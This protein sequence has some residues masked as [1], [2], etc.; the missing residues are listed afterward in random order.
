MQTLSLVA[1][2]GGTGKTTLAL[3]LAVAAEAAGKT[4]LIIDL[5]PQASACKWGDRR[6]SDGP[7]VIDAQP[8]RLPNALEKAAHAGVDLAIVDT[9]AR[10]EQAAAEAARASDL[11]IIPCKPSIYDLETLHATIDL[12]QSR[13]KRP[14]IV[15]L[16][17]VAAHGTRHEQAMQAIRAMGVAV[18]P[19]LIGQRVAFE[20]AAQLGQSAAEY[21][22][23]GKAASEIR[24]LYKSICRGLDT[25]AKG[26]FIHDE[27]TT[28]SR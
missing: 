13:A 23:R 25:S 10:I 4:T 2:K 26:D 3:S 22:P 17:A 12:V 28:Q 8:S 21:E 19:A 20:Y 1:Q 27:K 15:V 14:P 11:V 16:N 9:P 24:H 18:C 6:T 5:D 7:T